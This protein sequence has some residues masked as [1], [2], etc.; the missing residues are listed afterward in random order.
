MADLR[1]RLTMAPSILVRA[2]GDCPQ[3]ACPS[4]ATL[5]S[6]AAVEPGGV[7]YADV[8]SGL[9]CRSR[10]ESA[11]SRSARSR[12]WPPSAVVDRP[13]GDRDREALRAL[14]RHAPRAVVVDRREASVVVPALGE[15]AVTVVALLRAPHL[16]AHAVAVA[17][18]GDEHA[19]ARVVAQLQ[20]QQPPG[21]S[22]LQARLVP[23]DVQAVR[24]LLDPLQP[25]V[26]PGGPGG[27]R[28][29]GD[30]A[31]QLLAEPAALDDEALGV[32]VGARCARGGCRSWRTSRRARGSCR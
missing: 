23:A 30:A 11:C 31:A 2:R 27:R 5:A 1:S 21:D 9:G 32:P 25:G 15:A 13:A 22:G 8:A 26:E 20:V 19:V 18:G 4:P 3:V 17:R 29:D 10:G 16:D 6:P 24:M 28:D 7:R 12:C 14:G